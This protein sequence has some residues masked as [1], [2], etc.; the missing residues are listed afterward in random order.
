M[1]DIDRGAP[2]DLAIFS[3][4]KTPEQKEYARRKSQHYN[5]AFACRESNSSARE[6]VARESIVMADV[7]TNVII[8]DEYTFITDL[9]YSLSSRYQRPESSILVTVSH[10]AC[11]LFGGSFDPAY[12]LTITALPSQVQPV[13]NKRN[14]ALLQKNMEDALGVSPERG[15]VKFVAI[16]E[17]NMATNGRTAAGE[18]E[19]LESAEGINRRK[20]TAINRKSSVTPGGANGSKRKSTR[21]LKS[22]KI[23]TNLPT[24]DEQMTPPLSERKDSPP[25]IPPVPANPTVKS[26]LDKKA[27]KVQRMGKR[28]SFMD[29]ILGRI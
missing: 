19:D 1:R 3:E 27:E 13:T 4:R 11:L 20:S 9:S 6:R 15:L 23:G 28:K 16:A 21:S 14:A 24:H 8:Q 5:D 10:S 7:R 25:P 29:S 22:L 17:E 12:T 26:A 2:G 18:I